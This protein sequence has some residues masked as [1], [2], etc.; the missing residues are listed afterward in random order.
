MILKEKTGSFSL[1]GN[2]MFL[3]LSKLLPLLVYPLG[4]ACV[5]LVVALLVKGQSKWLKRWV[6]LALAILWIGGNNWVSASLVR[7][8]EWRYLPPETVPEA[9]AIVVLGGATEA[10]QYPRQMV[11]LN[12]A[13]DRLLYAS[14]L[15]HQGAAPHLLLS[16]GYISWLGDNAGSP[17]EEMA[18]VLEMLGVPPEAI[19]L[20]IDSQNTYENAVFSAGIL[21]KAGIRRIILVTSAQHMPRAVA[22][23]EKQGL[24]VIPAPADYAVTQEN[25]DYLWEPSFTA[26]V[27]N[28]LPSVGNLSA[29]TQVLKEYLGVMVYSLRGWI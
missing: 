23:F 13:G 17:A 2:N 24:D 15:Y 19:W 1:P 14:W 8:L 25:W 3:F 20:E 11:E 7:S 26:Q 10:A 29:T 4:L 16:G 5:F 28:L 12:G 18:A 27:F 9:Q 6:G 22:L 21:E